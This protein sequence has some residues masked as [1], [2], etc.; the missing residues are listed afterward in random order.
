MHEKEHYEQCLHGGDT[1][2]DNYIQG[3][4]RDVGTAKRQKQESEQCTPYSEVGFLGNNS[5]GPHAR[6]TR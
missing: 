2:V 4:E 6:A 3:T 5:V 1:E